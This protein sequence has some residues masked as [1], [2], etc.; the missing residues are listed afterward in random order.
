MTTRT[1]LD[2]RL[3]RW[4]TDE[5][6]ERA[7]DRLIDDV[8]RV[9]ELTSQRPARRAGPMAGAVTFWR[10]LTPSRRLL[11]VATM[12]V[13][14]FAAG[15]AAALLLR[16]PDAPGPG[17]ILVRYHDPGDPSAGVV[18]L[19]HQ[20]AATRELLRLDAS[21]LGGVWNGYA[22]SLGPTGFLALGIGAAP[23]D[24]VAILDV[25][26]EDAVRRLDTVGDS[27]S[28]APDGRRIA[29]TDDGGILVFDVASG[30]ISRVMA[31]ESLVR[32]DDGLVW[33]SDGSGFIADPGIE[34]LGVERLDGTFVPGRVPR[35]DPGVGPRRIRGDG[36]LLRCHATHDSPCDPESRSLN[37]IG[38]SAAQIWSSDDLP[39]RIADF[40]WTT[41][42]GIWVLT[43]TVGPG[44]RTVSLLRVD[45]DGTESVTTSFPAGRPLPAEQ[46]ICVAAQFEAMAPDDSRLV[47]RT[48]GDDCTEGGLYVLD[49]ATLQ[50]V[51]IEGIVAGWLDPEDLERPGQ[52]LLPDREAPSAML[53]YWG[54]MVASEGPDTTDRPAWLSIRPSR[55][56]VDLGVDWL[57]DFSLNA[58]DDATVRLTTPSRDSLGCGTQPSATYRWR[59]SVTGLSLSAVDDACAARRALLEGTFE[60]ALAY[61][62]SSTVTMEPGQTYYVPPFAVRITVPSSGRTIVAERDWSSVGFRTDTGSGHW[63]LEQAMFAGAEDSLADAMSAVEAAFD[64]PG[65]TSTTVAGAPAVT[66]TLHVE[67]SEGRGRTSLWLEDM[68]VGSVLQDGA[69]VTLVQSDRGDIYSI[70]AWAEGPSTTEVWAWA[71]ALTGSIDFASE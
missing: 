57:H 44:P 56:R 32:L 54:R 55:A 15:A 71:D 63:V 61:S 50:M 62:G 37:A 49:V 3:A 12:I 45:P 5:A 24:Q 10:D 47:I 20:A 59:T 22:A 18:V 65:W 67:A 52:S 48:T 8:L 39:I 14:T 19:E 64:D 68:R 7:P 27:W 51:A 46:G 35:F 9:V 31:D 41:E 29:T 33:A 70:V 40:A 21:A 2:R 30:E 17:L 16:P 36:T 26:G 13:A 53:G 66:G 58:I 28:W 42:G 25:R 4:F 60:R 6:P 34:T 23:D 69:R 38:G 1:D 11:L 43:E